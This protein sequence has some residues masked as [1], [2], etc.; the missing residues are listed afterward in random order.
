[1][2]FQVVS[3]IDWHPCRSLWQMSRG[4]GP[5]YQQ[6]ML[7]D[8]IA[9][10]QILDVN[11]VQPLDPIST[12]D[13]QIMTVNKGWRSLQHMVSEARHVADHARHWLWI[14]VNVGFVYTETT[15]H[16]GSAADDRDLKILNYLE[17]HL[18][19]WCSVLKHHRPDDRGRLGNFEHPV[20]VL[21]MR[22]S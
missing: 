21:A 12:H 13:M 22:R 1:M 4:P 2:K 16:Y 9:E 19:G 20:T 5:L 18:D 11:H 7:Q 6:Q 10:H 14:A 8:F 17:H 15:Q 3:S